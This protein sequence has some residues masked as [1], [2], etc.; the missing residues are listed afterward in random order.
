[1]ICLYFICLCLAIFIQTNS[2]VF[3]S[4]FA[5]SRQDGT[6]SRTSSRT[7]HDVLMMV[8]DESSSSGSYM[9]KEFSLYEELEEIV[10]LASQP[11]PERPDGIVVVAKF[12][13]ASRDECRVT[14]PDYERLARN[15]PATIFLR[16]LEEYDNAHL[17][18][19]QVN[20]QVWP[21]YDIFYGGNR[22]AR[23][24]GSNI[25]ELEESIER[26]QFQNSNL[27]LFSEEASQKRQLQWGDG[28]SKADMNRTPRT[29]NRFVP[30]Y[31][32]NTKKGFFD[33]QGEKAQQSFEDTFGNWLPNLDDDD[34]EEGGSKK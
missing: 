20:V 27:D 21:T 19:G 11:I 18:F 30:G 29:T 16:C 4:G 1:M 31:D 33:E 2:V 22:V 12:S 14:E 32:W 23:I 3:V 13:A 24:E 34:N 6:I 28:S 7:R 5:F 10:Q 26:Y 15:N 25:A 9:V 8:G 17:L